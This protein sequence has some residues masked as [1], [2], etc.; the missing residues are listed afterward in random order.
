MDVRDYCETVGSELAAW[1][2]KLNEVYKKTDALK[3]AER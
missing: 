3:G 1:K 2:A